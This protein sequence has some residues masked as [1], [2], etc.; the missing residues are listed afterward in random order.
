MNRSVRIRLDPRSSQPVYLQIVDQVQRHS[1]SGRLPAGA[2][3]PT[4]RE[5]ARQLGVNFNTVARA[6]RLL[7]RNGA[8]SPRPGRGTFILPA[9]ARR[10]PKRAVLQELAAEYIGRARRMGFTDVHIAAALQHGLGHARLPLPPGDND[11]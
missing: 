11:G 8:V 1:G 7:A 3:L 5:L 9:A 2:R 6:Y 10:K 4:V